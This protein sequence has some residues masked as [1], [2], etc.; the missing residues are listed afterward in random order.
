MKKSEQLIYDISTLEKQ[1]AY[2]RGLEVSSK[3]RIHLSLT[4][5]KEQSLGNPIDCD[6]AAL[7]SYLEHE[8][9]KKKQDHRLN[10]ALRLALC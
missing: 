7:L 3:H 9:K 1:I 10:E 2:I 5:E 8:L 6:I 4:N